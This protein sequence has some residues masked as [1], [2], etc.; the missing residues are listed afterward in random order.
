V[1]YDGEPYTQDATKL[2][3][4]QVRIPIPFSS[5]EATANLQRVVFLTLFPS[6]PCQTYAGEQN[7]VCDGNGTT[8][9]APP[10]IGDDCSMKDCKSNCSFNGWCSVEYPVSRC[11][12]QPGYY[13]DICQY[14][15]CLNNCS[16]P[17]GNCNSTDGTCQCNMMYSPYNNTREYH[18]WD[19]EDCS[20]IFAYAGAGRR[21][22]WVRWSDVD[23]R[24][25]VRWVARVAWRWVQGRPVS[26]PW[27]PV[28]LAAVAGGGDDAIAAADWTSLLRVDVALVWGAVLAFTLALAADVPRPLLLR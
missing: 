6:R 12:C 16:Y 18:P 8:Y 23:V 3:C 9:C 27:Q 5:P 28:S 10:F 19:G 20:Y 17:N 22:P 7:G 11:L 24:G 2:P 13:G 4:S 1:H 15:L 25:A 14:K 26:G 21:V